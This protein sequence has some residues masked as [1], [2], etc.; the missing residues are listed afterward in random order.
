M[1]NNL[2]L[3]ISP[4]F[5]IKHYLLRDIAIVAKKYHF[6]GK[7]LDIGCGEK[8]Y[9]NLFSK[10]EYVGIDFEKFSKNNDLSCGQPDFFF[11]E[12]YSEYLCLPFEDD[13]FD[14]VV[15]FQVLE[16]H[17]DPRVFMSEICRVSKP[18]GLVL[19]TVPFMG[20]I[21]EE[22]HDYQRFTK[23]GLTELFRGNGFEVLEIKEQGS[24]FSTISMLL[25]EH[26]NAFAA[27][28][29][30]HYLFATFTYPPFLLLQYVSMML[31]YVFPSR[32]IFINYIIVGKN[33]K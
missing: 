20:G 11:P 3:Y 4:F 13:A 27:R 12:D 30:L 26:L 1:F 21:H 9:A 14:H 23:Y 32:K 31:D 10:S 5:V 33:N 7:V 8:P 2:R 17:R 16:H 25:N 22:P 29:K 18:G 24:I 6:K 15:A 19:L 28:G